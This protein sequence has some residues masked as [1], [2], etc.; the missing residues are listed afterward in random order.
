MIP[1]EFEYHAPKTIPDALGLLKQ[2][3]DEAKLLAGGHS[4]LP[5]MKMRFAQPAHLIDL[6]RIRELKGIR[7]DGGTPGVMQLVRA[8]LAVQLKDAMGVD[9]I[10]TREKKIVHEVFSRLGTSSRITLL[11][12]RHQERLPII[13]FY[14]AGLHYNLIV[15][16]LNDR[17]GIQARGGCS[18]A[19]T[20]G[21]FLHKV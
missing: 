2:L 13:S 6:G 12:S 10:A 19:G 15:R 1:R 3:G 8:A 5:M 4:L 9:R 20:Y 18:C 7:E 16:M 11:A 17:F 21:H 14:I